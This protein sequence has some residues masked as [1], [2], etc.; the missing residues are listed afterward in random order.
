[1]RRYYLKVGDKSTAGGTTIE[2]IPSCTHHG[3]ELTFLGARVV[4]PACGT[5][6]RIIPKGPRWTDNLMGKKAALDGDLC[7]CK[8][9][10]PP[11]MLA[12]Q[13]TMFQDFEVCHLAD[14]GFAPNGAPLQIS[15][16]AM[17]TH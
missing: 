12:S 8:C 3:T 7:A 5:T 17:V 13:N 1:M 11:L 10:P 9:D 16:S 4:C 6:G 15:A 14:M 2:G